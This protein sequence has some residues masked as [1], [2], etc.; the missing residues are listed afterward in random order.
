MIHATL[1]ASVVDAATKAAIEVARAAGSCAAGNCAGACGWILEGNVN[2]WGGDLMS[3]DNVDVE[4]I[5]GCAALCERQVG[6]Q[7][8]VHVNERRWPIATRS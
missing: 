5:A 8:F 3:Y 2:Y 7:G 6:C 1:S 4:T